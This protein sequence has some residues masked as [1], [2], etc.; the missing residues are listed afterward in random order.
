MI[1][2]ARPGLFVFLIPIS[3]LFVFTFFWKHRGSRTLFPVEAWGKGRAAWSR[4]GEKVLSVI[5]SLCFLSAMVMTV[6]AAAGPRRVIKEE[7]YESRGADIVF[8]LDESPSM[9]AQDFTPKN[10]FE[11]AKFVIRGFIEDRKNDMIGLVSFGSEASLRIPPTRDYETYRERLRSLQ[12]GGM[13][14]GTAIGLGIGVAV[15]HLENS[16]APDKIVILLTDGENNA[17]KVSPG[18]AARL[19][20]SLGIRMYVVGLGKAGETGLTYTDPETGE[21]IR[22]IYRGTFD[23]ELLD[24]LASNT[25]GSFFSAGSST[26]LVEAL[27]RIH[28]L[29]APV[30]DISYRFSEEPVHMP[31]LI[32][33]LFLL[34]AATLL[35]RAVLREVFP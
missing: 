31:C 23:P 8:V 29:E 19:A 21:Q 20:A 28:I 25:G 4:N 30:T 10:R 27:R 11:A 2:F 1:S 13:G 7:I 16:T 24:A 35:R 12:L 18:L 5:A 15:S 26:A 32:A 9:A 17:G 14:E 3:L 6:V 22:G 33:A 34:P